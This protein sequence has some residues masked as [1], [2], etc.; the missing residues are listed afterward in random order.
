[1]TFDPFHVYSAYGMHPGITT[2]LQTP[3]AAMNPL[4]G[5]QGWGQPG[6][7]QQG[8][9]QQGYPVPTQQGYPVPTQQGYNPLLAQQ[10]YNP[11]LLQI[12]AGVQQPSV[13]P[14]QVLAQ[15]LAAQAIA[16]QLLA[17]AQHPGIAQQLYGLNPQIGYAGS[18][19][20]AGSP[21]GQIGPQLLPQT[22]IGQ[23][24]GACGVRGF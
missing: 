19:F 22:W 6:F 9:G 4:L 14:Q 11:W 15:V 20:G 16:P 18:P 12:G 2:P 10:G 24:A 17:L 7:V 13:N 8:L 1:V 21:Y 3:Y 5:Q 23:G